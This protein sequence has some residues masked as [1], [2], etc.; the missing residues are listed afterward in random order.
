M[1]FEGLCELDFVKYIKSFNIICCAVETFTRV[2][3]D[4]SIHFSHYIVLHSPAKKCRKKKKEINFLNM[5]D[6]QEA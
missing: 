3:F 1:N 6:D 5:E 4:F 2:Q